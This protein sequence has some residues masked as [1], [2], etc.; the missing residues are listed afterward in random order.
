M[1]SIREIR[2]KARTCGVPESTIERDYAQNWFLGLLFTSWKDLVLK[3]GT[4]IRK[5][6]LR[7]YR[8]S[9]DLDF[10]MIREVDEEFAKGSLLEAV[11][12]TKEESGIRFE[13]NTVLKE[14]INGF[15]GMVYFRLLRVTGSP[16]G[17]KLDFT[18]S[19]MEEV[20]LPPLKRR[21]IHPYSDGCRFEVKVYTIEEII[22]EKIRSLFERTRP[23]DLYDVWYFRDKVNFSDVLKIFLKKCKFKGMK[24]ELASFIERRDDFQNSW[25]NSLEH[26][27]KNLPDFDDIYENVSAMLKRYL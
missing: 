19:D 15:E 24:P 27:L 20:L 18:K 16:I 14:N 5:S 10:T 23:R 26:Q 13:G 21:I 8:F 25:K 4:G 22:G 11:E 3:G 1:I 17:I 7:D 12:K 2:E 6:Y 9:D